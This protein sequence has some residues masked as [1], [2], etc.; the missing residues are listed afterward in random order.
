M[1]NCFLMIRYFNYQPGIKIKILQPGI[2]YPRVIEGKG[3]NL[4]QIPDWEYDKE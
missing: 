1:S 3:K 2:I 4:E